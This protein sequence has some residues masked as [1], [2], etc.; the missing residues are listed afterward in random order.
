MVSIQTGFSVLSGNRHP[1]S[2]SAGKTIHKKDISNDSVSTQ[3]FQFNFQI[4]TTTFENV[5]DQNAL[6]HF[7]PLNKEDKAQLFYNDTPVSQLSADEANQLISADGYFG[8]AKTSQR[9]ID[10]VTSGAGEDI[11][12]LRAGR[13]GVLRGFAEAEKAWGGKLPG[14]SYET[15]EKSLETI[16]EKIR[17]LGGSVMDLST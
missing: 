12:R 15:L 17:E 2:P 7:N 11:D 14:I 8:V 16:D 4:T 9:I 5:S 13:E 1:M 6:F 3:R 10:F